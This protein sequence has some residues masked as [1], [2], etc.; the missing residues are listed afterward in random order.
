LIKVAA[1]RRPI[2]SAS[3]SSWLN[4]SAS[5]PPSSSSSRRFLRPAEIWLMTVEPTAPPSVS[6][7]TIATS[8]VRIGRAEPWPL[9]DWKAARGSL[10]M[11]W[12]NA[13]IVRAQRR[14]MRWP[15]MNSA[16]SHQCEPMSANARDAPPNSSSTRQL[17]SSGRSSQSCK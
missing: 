14:E 12:G 9:T 17:S 1:S 2:H 10:L 7:C 5:S 11:R 13:I 4:S 6:N 8:S 3:G 15:E 16:R